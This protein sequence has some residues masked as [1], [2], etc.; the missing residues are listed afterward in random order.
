MT[1]MQSA[2][3][4][5]LLCGQR[6]FTSSHYRR[7]LFEELGSPEKYRSLVNEDYKHVESMVVGRWVDNLTHSSD[8]I[9]DWSITHLCKRSIINEKPTGAQLHTLSPYYSR[10]SQ[11]AIQAAQKCGWQQIILANGPSNST[12]QISL[13]RRETRT[14]DFDYFLNVRVILHICGVSKPRRASSTSCLALV[15][16]NAR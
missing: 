4:K 8:F 11:Q 5:S 1:Q 14:T 15:S 2:G 7:H 16:R 3:L 12:A 13:E 10:P 6:I 9:L